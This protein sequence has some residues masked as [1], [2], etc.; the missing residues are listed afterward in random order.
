MDPFLLASPGL[1]P[2]VTPGLTAGAPGGAR[3]PLPPAGSRRLC[4]SST[5]STQSEKRWRSR[6]FATA[7]LTPGAEASESTRLAK[8]RRPMKV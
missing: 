3:P 6:S 4:A 1:S 2:G 7:G 8:A 5:I